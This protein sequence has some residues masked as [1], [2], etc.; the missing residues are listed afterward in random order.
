MIKSV[1]IA[2]F[3]ETLLAVLPIS[4]IVLI[5]NFTLAP[6]ETPLII[7]FI[8]GALL[9]ILGLTV[10]LFG[11][12]I[13]ITPIGNS[14]GSAI[15]KSNKMKIVIAAGLIFGFIVT[16]AEP[17]LH[18]LA[19]QIDMVSKGMI[20]KNALV[21]VVSVGTAIM[22]CLGLVRIVRNYALHKILF[23][24]FTIIL[25]FSFFSSSEYIAIAFDASGAT[26]G[27][28][29]VPF[30]LALAT[31]V[32]H[33]KK[34]SLS[35]EKDSF[36]LVAIASTG[37]IL[38]V[39]I[40]NIITKPE[41]IMNSEATLETASES[42]I[43]PFIQ[44]FPVIAFEVLIALAPILLIF[45]ILK[46]KIFKLSKTEIRKIF[47]GMLFTFIGLTLFLT[48]VNA[49]FMEVGRV[50]GF[51]L[52]SRNSPV[53]LLIT[54]FIL[55]MVTI[56]AEPAVHVLT[57]QIEDVT[58]GYIKR[59]VVLTA[60]SAG[61]ALAVLL[62]IVRIIVPNIQ[63]W[64]YLLPGY[65][66][67]VTMTFF[68][69]KLFVG[70]A[71]DSG[72]VASGPMTATFILAFAQGAAQATKGADVLLDGFGVIAMVAMTP[73]IALQILGLIFRIKSKRRNTTNDK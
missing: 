44:K 45:I 17:D 27:A 67:A 9:I 35:S 24:L 32:A 54:A 37:A 10:F 72:G 29:T 30:I 42:I 59:R 56:L 2:K 46:R 4:A 6:I 23:V 7:R 11:V 25:I 41:K 60:L 34:D 50:V 63:L 48:G 49:G 12:D 53:F 8:I 66:I 61:V 5:L 13:G 43:Y 40:M 73:L 57:H 38:S 31:G 33:L 22:V 20:A 26:T 62:S 3:K 68:V 16:I 1:I 70:I 21:I 47:Y 64:H 69:P 36:G 15:T 51:M 14:V 58:S 52:A 65:I 18:I 28:L 19:E 55:G 39:L 71:F